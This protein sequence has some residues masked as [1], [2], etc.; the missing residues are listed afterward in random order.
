MDIKVI[1]LCSVNQKV[2]FKYDESRSKSGNF[3]E[4]YKK[5]MKQ[6]LIA[7][8]SFKF[9]NKETTTKILDHELNM[10]VAC[11]QCC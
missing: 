8:N 3:T 1:W 9:S 5:I 2:I 6:H 4:T 7:F 10:L 11:N